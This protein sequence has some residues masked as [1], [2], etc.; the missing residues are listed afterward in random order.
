MSDSVQLHHTLPIRQCTFD[1][2]MGAEGSVLQELC[3]FIILTKDVCVMT[4]RANKVFALQLRAKIF[5][6]SDFF[7]N[8]LHTLV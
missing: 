3:L 5:I 6:D 8:Y 2:K 1:R 4:D 7:Q